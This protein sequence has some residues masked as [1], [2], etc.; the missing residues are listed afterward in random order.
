[1]H[2]IISSLASQQERTPLH[3]SACREQKSDRRQ[4][5]Q[6][7]GSRSEQGVVAGSKRKMRAYTL[8]PVSASERGFQMRRE[9]RKQSAEEK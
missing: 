2:R 8:E 9:M 1:M 5:K 6:K 7:G 3:S 4:H